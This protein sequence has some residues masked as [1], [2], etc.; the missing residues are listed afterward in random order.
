MANLI[1]T[2]EAKQRFAAATTLQEIND[3][4]T[5]LTA[6]ELLQ[7]EE[8]RGGGLVLVVENK[9]LNEV[10]SKRIGFPVPKQLDAATARLYGLKPVGSGFIIPKKQLTRAQVWRAIKLLFATSIKQ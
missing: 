3:S 5:L 9:E 10:I 6:Y 1:T 4:T 8:S 2:W 7:E